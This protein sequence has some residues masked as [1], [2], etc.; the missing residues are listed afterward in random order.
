MIKIEV[1]TILQFKSSETDI[2][3]I[4]LHYQYRMFNESF[5][6]VDE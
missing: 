2:I 3:I 6:R 5:R 1:G 4:R